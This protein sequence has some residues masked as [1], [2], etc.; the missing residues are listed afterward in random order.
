MGK[1]AYD[2]QDMPEH[3]VELVLHVDETLT[4]DQRSNLVNSLQESDGIEKAEFSTLR[5]HLMLVQYDRDR[6]NS[7]EVLG[8]V[9]SESVHA[10]LV[11]P[12]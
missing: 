1:V 8:R 4:D 10:E 7:Q 2:L 6:I 3:N 9:T 11:G 12:V 5:N